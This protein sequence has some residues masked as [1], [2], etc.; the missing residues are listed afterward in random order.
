ME[1]AWAYQHRP[2]V[3]GFLAE[4][5][6]ILALSDEVKQI[7]W[8]AQQRLHKRYQ[9]FAAPRQEQESD[10]DG[11]GPRAA[12]VRV[13]HRGAHRSTTQTRKGSLTGDVFLDSSADDSAG[14]TKRRTLLEILCGTVSGP[15]PRN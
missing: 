10:R 2:N 3:T 5:A 4:K 15:N 8:K 12:R 7:A 14:P 6:K 11:V 13:G 1:A 9:A